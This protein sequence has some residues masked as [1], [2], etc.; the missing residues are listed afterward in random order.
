MEQIKIMQGI[1]ANTLLRFQRCFKRLIIFRYSTLTRILITSLMKQYPK[2]YFTINEG[3]LQ[4]GN[5]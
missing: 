1:Y 4:S 3:R 2:D 5:G